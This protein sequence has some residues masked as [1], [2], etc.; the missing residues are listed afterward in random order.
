MVC[1]GKGEKNPQRQIVPT[2]IRTLVELKY[3]SGG[4]MSHCFYDATDKPA[5]AFPPKFKPR[6]SAK[7]R[8]LTSASRP[9][10]H[11]VL[12]EVSEPCHNAWTKRIML[13]RL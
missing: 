9:Q 8:L 7:H 5:V 3:S 11:L 6:V 1:Q 12:V 10:R 4:L 13:C 2:P